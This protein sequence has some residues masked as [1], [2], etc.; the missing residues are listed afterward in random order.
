MDYNIDKNKYKIGLRIREQ[1]IEAGYKNQ[2]DFAVALGLQEDSR[3]S[4]GAWENG[5]RLPP[6]NI[7]LKMC[8]LF[9]C[10][11][12]YL[13]CEY[14]C[15]TREKTDIKMATGLSEKSIQQLFIFRKRTKDSDGFFF[16]SPINSIIENDAFV[17]LI[18]AIR[19]HVWSFNHNHNNIENV[20]AEV[21]EALSNTFNCEPYEIKG[22][23]EMSS[24]SLIESII[25]K[26]IRDI[27]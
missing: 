22:Y 15:K 20:N 2:S 24:Q 7:L 17:E 14:D 25:M 19:K 27:K 11:L 12:G 23:I 6:I 26:I 4:V 9:D 18:E 10:E 5:S 21:Q 16:D 13:F 8:K 1:R 3:Q